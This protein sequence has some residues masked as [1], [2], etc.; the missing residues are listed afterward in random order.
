MTWRQQLTTGLILA[1]PSLSASFKKYKTVLNLMLSLL[2]DTL[3]GL[4]SLSNESFDSY[5]KQLFGGLQLMTC[6]HNLTL[7]SLPQ[8][9]LAE[10]LE[11]GDCM[12]E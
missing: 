6:C 9:S 3:I 5:Q 2:V 1:I 12:A 11:E 7:P 4:S 8:D 10:N